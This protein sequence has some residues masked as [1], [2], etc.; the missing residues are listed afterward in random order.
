MNGFQ[1]LHPALQHHIV[2]S[3]GWTSLRP[4]QEAAIEPVL[5]GKHAV[6]LAPTAGGKT[7]AVLFPTLS[8]MLKEDWRGLSV[9]YLC[10]LKA[11]INNLEIRLSRYLALLGRRCAIWH[12]DVGRGQRERMLSEPPDLL[13]TTPESLE[14]MLCS[15]V[16]DGATFLSGVRVVIIDEI[17]SFAGDD[18]GIHLLALLARIS[19]LCGREF[20]RLALSATIGNPDYLAEWM[21]AGCS[22]ERAVLLPPATVSVQADIKLDYVGSISNAAHV[23]SR[24]F[25]GEKRLVF[26]DS[27][28]RAEHLGNELRKLGVKTYI[29][30]SSL[31]RSHRDDAEEAFQSAEDCVIVAT[32]VLELGVDVGDLDRVIQIDAPFSVSS[33]LQ[34]MGRT[35]RREGA[36]RNCLFLATREQSLLRG[37]GLIELYESGYI[38]DVNPPEGVFNILA[39]QLLALVL[40]E[41]GIGR[42]TWFNW[43]ASVPAFA[44]MD[45]RKI[46]YLVSWMLDHQVLFEDQG[47]LSFGQKAEKGYGRKNFMELLSVFLSPPIFAVCQGNEEIGYLDERF[48]LDKEVNQKDLLLA[49]QT[50]KVTH[51]DWK[52]RRAYVEPGSSDGSVWWAGEGLG[53]SFA[54]AQAVKRILSTDDVSEA[55]SRRAVERLKELRSQV[56]WLEND[57]ATYLVRE[58]KNTF[59]WTFAGARANAQLAAMLKETFADSV[60]HDDLKIKLPANLNQE[61]IAD[62]IDMLCRRKGDLPTP[63]VNED[64]LEGLKFSKIIPHELAIESIAC[65]L[66]DPKSLLAILDANIRFVES[67][68]MS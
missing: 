4:F 64:A 18:R 8:R 25:R 59:W 33:F 57:D 43:L 65:R 16:T 12:G 2:N 17:H 13:L 3:L 44:A 39:Q 50:W 15:S 46:E 31:S 61:Y 35:G 41:H 67:T 24:I 6:I 32:S 40:Q 58:E 23:L 27:R 62:A 9:L 29:T 55:W 42:N 7:E 5:S 20:Q 63:L 34:R 60:R 38:E 52:R 14:V 53:S 36:V 48:F 56:S 49:G 51:I 45:Q 30:H 54:L 28:A 68:S 19:R 11:L 37:A 21:T 22:G 26:I 10:P 1:H 66:K 47:I